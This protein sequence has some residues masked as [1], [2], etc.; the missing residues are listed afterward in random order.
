MAKI[1]FKDAKAYGVKL[2]MLEK[3]FSGDKPLE[4]AV[5]AG[6]NVLADA[7]RHSMDQLPT[8]QFRRLGEGDRFEDVPLGQLLELQEHF[9]VTPVRRDKNGFVNAKIGWEGYNKYRT[10]TYPQGVP[11]AL[12]AGAI[13]SGSS[14]R[15]KHPFIRPAVK[16]STPRALKTMSDHIDADCQR[17]MEGSSSKIFVE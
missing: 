1:T 12:I 14:V 16:I 3:H 5:E 9:G 6:A 11:N 4:K 7:I 10:K 2:E 15:N 8:E 13:E 17:V